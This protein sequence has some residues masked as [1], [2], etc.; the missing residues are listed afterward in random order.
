MLRT[1]SSTQKFSE[2]PRNRSASHWALR[3]SVSEA[4]ALR[5]DD[6]NLQGTRLWCD[7]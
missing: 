2:A 7:A 6:I 4:I 1:I 5:R 3:S